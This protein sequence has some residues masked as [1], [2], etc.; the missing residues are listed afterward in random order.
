MKNVLYVWKKINIARLLLT[1]L[2]PFLIHISATAQIRKIKLNKNH[3]LVLKDTIIRT[4]HDT[5]IYLP[6]TVKYKKRR[7]YEHYLKHKLIK[8]LWD[9]IY[10]EKPS[11]LI[12][13]D[14][15]FT[16]KSENPYVAYEGRKIRNIYVKKQDIFGND[17]YDT[18]YFKKLVM[19][20]KI[21]DLM[22]EKTKT[23]V[24]KNNLFIKYDSIVDQNRLADNERLLR[25][26]TYMHDARI[27]VRP[28]KDDK[29]SM[30][31]IEVLVQDLWSIGGS[32]SAKDV[33][34]YGWRL[35][36]RN[37]LGYGQSISYRGQ[38]KTPGT[39]AIS[40]EFEYVKDNFLGWFLSPFATY[41]QLNAGPHIGKENETS[42]ILGV[43]RAIYMP[44]ARL[45]GGYSYSNNWS[46]N[47]YKEADTSFYDYKYY[48][49]DL[50]GGFTFSGFRNQHSEYDL[51]TRQN[52]ARIFLSGRYYNRGFKK[53]PYQTDTSSNAL[54]HNQ[55]SYIGQA[56]Y[57]KY[58]FY[59]TRY[60]YGFGR[61]ED[62]P[63]GYSYLINS[64]IDSRLNQ[65]RYYIG[66]ATFNSWVK[67]NGDFLLLDLRA[68]AFYN[69]VHAL[70]DI[71][72][73][74]EGTYV[75]RILNM[76]I[77]K[78]R[79][80]ATLNYA[81]M[82]NPQ[83]NGALNINDVNGL[84]QFN[85]LTLLGYQTSSFTFTANLFP[86]FRALGFRFAF[87][88]ITEV[89]QIGSE[90][91]FLFNNKIYTGLGAG[92]RAKN[93]NLALDEVEVRFYFFPNGPADVTTFKIVTS[94]SPRLRINLR[95]IGEPGFIGL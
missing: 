21:T 69:S 15:S 4:T 63:K 49:H 61:T 26:L 59:K 54:Y 83:L 66:M 11:S 5:V 64:G 2:I 56:T 52:R 19:L 10:I 39:P 85:S 80:F 95:G 79:F 58:D 20:E 87:I 92:F 48:V 77:W 70:Q 38:Y 34:Y 22:H 1:L 40:S 71:F 45:A 13:Y 75:T 50:W 9:Q 6:L 25:S 17:I 89:A 36:D 62:I 27:F 55:Y 46:V 28:V 43:N 42:I 60:L 57:F 44:T 86:R 51:I 88:L 81:K 65:L 68:S 91:E 76:G 18:V 14:T 94:T 74:G 33:T 93:E 29:D 3:F 8:Q 37:F 47:T 53:T 67:K 16:V 90:S 84:Q 31:D 12:D 7:D 73:K 23:I 30:V 41:S 24:I 78:G 32:F 35:Y 82:I 72:V